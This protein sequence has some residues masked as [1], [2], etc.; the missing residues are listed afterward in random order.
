LVHLFDC[1]ARGLYECALKSSVSVKKARKKRKNKNAVSNL[2][3][4]QPRGGNNVRPSAM[5]VQRMETKSK[6][7]KKN[8]VLQPLKSTIEEEQEYSVTNQ[9]ESFERS[10]EE[11]TLDHKQNLTHESKSPLNNKRSGLWYKILLL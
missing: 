8:V 4:L 11:D 2:V 1:S 5:K 10:K 7:M 6:S 9:N 3:P